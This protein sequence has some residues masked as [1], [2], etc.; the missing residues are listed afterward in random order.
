MN[1]PI[2]IIEGWE[3]RLEPC[4]NVFDP[5][6]QKALYLLKD[7]YLSC[8][9]VSVPPAVVAWLLAPL[10]DRGWISGYA[11]GKAAGR[12]EQEPQGAPLNPVPPKLTEAKLDDQIARAR[13][14]CTCPKSGPNAPT[15]GMMRRPAIIVGHAPRCP[16]LPIIWGDDC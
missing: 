6:T 12:T 4:R 14:A 7:D 2:A 1:E 5:R 10:I 16:A 11:S 15:A 13:A 9:S 8:A 3:C